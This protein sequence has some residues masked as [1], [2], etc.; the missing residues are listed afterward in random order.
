MCRLEAFANT[1]SL[2]KLTFFQFFW[3]GV[4]EIAIFHILLIVTGKMHG[5]GLSGMY[6]GFETCWIQCCRFWVSAISFRT[7]YCRDSKPAA[8]DSAC[9]EPEIHATQAISMHF[10]S[11]NQQNVKYGY[12][13][14][15][16]WKKKLKKCQFAQGKSVC[17]GLQI[18]TYRFL[19]IPITMH[20]V[21]TLCDK[22]FLSYYGFSAFLWEG[23][24]IGFWNMA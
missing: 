20:Y 23:Q 7:A 24:D 4:K 1:F 9:L 2:C 10:P 18:C 16:P 5:N 13:L 19:D 15:S 6:I 3:G 14:N 11:H 21:R 17:K 12:F 8:L 22:Y